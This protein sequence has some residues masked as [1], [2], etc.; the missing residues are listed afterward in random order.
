MNILILISH[1]A[2]FH[3]FK[4]TIIGLKS[5]GHK[6]LI[7][8]KT[9]DILVK[10]LDEMQWDY[11]NI[12]QKE[13]GKGKLQILWSLIRRDIKVIY[14]AYR[15]K[16][17]LLIGTDASVA[18]ASMILRRQCIT[19]LE[20]D[21]NVI[22]K[23]CQLTYPYTNC[24]L[25]PKVCDVGKWGTKKVGYNGYMKLSYLHPNYF[26]PDINKIKIPT[27]KP[28]FLIRL[29]GL[30]AHHDDG[31]KG[32][33]LNF[34]DTMI[35]KIQQFGNVYIS[36]EKKLPLKYSDYLLKINI[37]DIHH[38]LSFAQMIICD[39]QSMSVE[40]AL[41][42]TPSIRISSFVGQISVLN[43]LEEN[44]KL[45]FG[46][47]P[48]NEVGILSKLDELLKRDNLK[49]EF[50]GL[51][52]NLLKEKIDVSRFLIWFI[53]NYPYSFEKMKKDPDYQNEFI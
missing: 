17:D 38:Y 13:R 45:T 19:T 5:H 3:F 53:E 12:I 43:E 25:V 24:I 47:L 2:Q 42:G 44:Y 14:Y 33:H 8:I 52:R 29:S 46:F 21:Y 18:H 4:N 30:T 7:L 49:N 32:I 22:R 39:S 35:N 40:A 50:S 20:D 9:K 41:L 16:S 51:L 37:L 34:L 15:F 48:D 11:I 1:P 36:S 6:V 31:I 26:T 27:D 28:F 10:L 23:L